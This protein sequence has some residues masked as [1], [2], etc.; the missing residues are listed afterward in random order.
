MKLRLFLTL[1]FL[2]VHALPLL[3]QSTPQIVWKTNAHGN[4]VRS[5]AFS[6]DSHFLA[7]G[8]QDRFAKVWSVPGGNLVREVHTDFG[9]AQSV[10]L[11]SDGSLLGVG[12]DYGASY[13][14][15]VGDGVRLW[16]AGSGDGD[17][18]L[19]VA[20]SPDD[21]RFADASW[22]DNKI[23]IRDPLTGFGDYL[24]SDDDLEYISGPVYEITFSP[25][26]TKLA[27][28]FSDGVAVLWDVESD[29]ILHVLDTDPSSV[30]FSP[31]GSLLATAG[32]HGTTQLWRVSD[33]ALVLAITNS[34]QHAKFLLNGRYVMTLFEDFQKNEFRIFRVSD[35]K[36]VGGYTNPPPFI[37]GYANAAPACFAV[38]RDGRYFSYGTWEGSIVLAYTPVIITSITHQHFHTTL[39]WEGGSGRYQVERRRLT[40]HAKWH[41]VGRPT[42][43]TA[44][45]V[46]G[47][48][49]F[50]YR[51]ISLT[52]K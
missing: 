2:W 6:G 7:S 25:D 22:S 47:R 18:I 50:E 44:K 35:G 1:L 37:D 30:D 20:F 15:R 16:R 34:G 45:C 26:G 24:G 39:Q 33:G 49:R 13:M 3:A 12:D 11:S 38:S 21:V 36:Y 10:A 9:S 31:D 17:F 5:V 52:P 42:T 41:K 14:W 27:S 8:S 23:I 19:T 46:L 29:Q 51:V 28:A 40:A 48:P 4:L 32:W 43:A